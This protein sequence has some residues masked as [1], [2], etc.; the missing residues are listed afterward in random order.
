MPE[1]VEGNGA[2]FGGFDRRFD[3]RFDKLTAPLSRREAGVR[4]RCMRVAWRSALALLIMGL[5]VGAV[6]ALAVQPRQDGGATP[7]L[8]A[9]A[10]FNGY[11]KVDTWLPVRVALSS[12]V[13]VEGEVVIV[14][15]EATGMRYATPV[16][17]TPGVRRDLTLYAPPGSNAVRVD[18]VSM[19]R[20]L[21]SAQP[22]LR[23]LSRQDRVVVVLGDPPDGFNFLT[24]LPTPFDGRSYVAH[25]TLDQLPDR[26]AALASIDA[27]VLSN[28]DTAAFSGAQHAA[29]RAWLVD[30]GHLIINGGPGAALT[31]AGL[32][33]VAPARASSALIATALDGLL[34]F[35]RPDA[36]SPLADADRG[37]LLAQATVLS[38]A[39]PDAQTLAA[40]R[41]TPLMMRRELGRGLVDQLAF[42][43]TLAPA[44]DWAGRTAVFGS[45]LGGR[46]D[47]PNALGAIRRDAR[48][49]TRDDYPA[50]VA[51]RALPGAA[52]PAFWVVAGFLV[53]YVLCLGPL[54]FMVLRR[55]RRP[56]L[57]WISIPVLVTAFT[58]L[59]LATGFR[60]RG[61]EPQIH[62]LSVVLGDARLDETGRA[63]GR[64]GAAAHSVVG[65]YAPRRMTLDVGLGRGLAREVGPTSGADAA[66]ARGVTLAYGDPDRL[67]G[68]EVGSTDVRAFYTRGE[69]GLPDVEADLRFVP[70]QSASDPAR[71]TGDIL[72]ASNAALSGCVLVVGRDYA[73]IGDIGPNQRA[74]VEARL[75]LN[76]PQPVMRLAQSQISASY[77]SFVGARRTSPPASRAPLALREPFDMAGARVV[78]MLIGWRDYGQDAM[79]AAAEGNLVFA[80]FG[81]PWDRLGQ[82][83]NL[84]C[85]EPADRS[86]AGAEGASYTDRG[87]RVWRLP[88]QPYLIDVRR[89]DAPEVV[90]PPDVFAWEIRATSS[91][92]RL[93]DSGLNLSPGRHVL[94]F[95]P[96]LGLRTTGPLTVVFEYEFSGSTRLSDLRDTTFWL[97]DWQA[98]AYTQV[99]TEGN[100]SGGQAIVR[101]AYVSPAGE[102]RVRVDN[103]AGLVTLSNAQVSLRAK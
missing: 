29:L 76:R 82:G 85:W 5:L 21:A 69:A 81:Q 42:D 61:N 14:S 17:L 94:G 64:A 84:A 48:R 60:L 26:S 98:R 71:I 103:E 10:G 72:N 90:A 3:K 51:A 35:A 101:G 19:G 93:T 59:G 12:V 74:P 89:G 96:W 65:V 16:A 41:D 83:V 43:A 11:A 28:A 100:S 15:E 102:V 50:L 95:S 23:L 63:A 91:S 44:R 56:E 24:A 52:L 66:S 13:A 8:A 6:P 73:A 37:D 58:V 1:P 87:L 18:F 39:A 70:G 34:D 75:Y 57:A 32:A 46:V 40:S 36:L 99:I 80:L 7:A 45:I 77:T 33:D 27:V 53:L 20:V 62:R 31:L 67:Q 49:D 25:I 88:V 47:L 38:P 79:R 30:G 55:L 86:G 4:M 68:L 97:Y 22:A 2:G 78:D 9:E 92:A 54:N